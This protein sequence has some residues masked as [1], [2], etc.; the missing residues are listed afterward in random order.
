MLINLKKLFQIKNQQF[1]N[2]NSN[3]RNS[4]A[5]KLIKYTI[6]KNYMNTY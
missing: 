4:I 6:R 3:K 5:E 1:S 2:N